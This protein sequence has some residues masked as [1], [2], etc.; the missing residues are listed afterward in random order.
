MEFG[1]EL[2]RILKEK[3][4]SQTKLSKITG[5]YKTTIRDWYHDHHSPSLNKAEL[6]LGVL[7]YEIKIVKKEGN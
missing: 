3:G 5:V 6:I 2:Q 1:K 4:V 7:G